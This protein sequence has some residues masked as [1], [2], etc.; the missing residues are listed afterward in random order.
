[1]TPGWRALYERAKARDMSDRKPLP[2]GVRVVHYR[3]ANSSGRR[4]R[5][6]HHGPE[7]VRTC[8]GSRR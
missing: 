8:R 1:M 5:S 2:N 7:R 3:R 4:W 6:F